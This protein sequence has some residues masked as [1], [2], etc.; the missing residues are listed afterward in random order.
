MKGPG[1]SDRIRDDGRRTDVIDKDG[2]VETAALDVG[3]GAG[4]L[5]ADQPIGRELP[6]AAD[7]APGQKS[8]GVDP[9]PLPEGSEILTRRIARAL[10]TDP[11]A[12]VAAQIAA[13]PSEDVN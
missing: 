13:G 9:D 2:L 7:L 5:D 1:G 12:A 4:P 6:I 10:A 3:P 8:A 11:A